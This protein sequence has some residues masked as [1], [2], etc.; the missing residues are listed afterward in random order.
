MAKNG[1]YDG[2]ADPVKSSYDKIIQE[3]PLMQDD[4]YVKID[5]K[6]ADVKE[7]KSSSNNIDKAS[8]YYSLDGNSWTKIGEDLGM[9]Y[10]L[11]LFTGYRSGIY[12][13]PTKNTGGYVDID[14]FDYQKTYDW[15][16]PV[17]VPPVEPDE[18][19]YYFHDTF[20]SDTKIEWEG[21]G[22]ASASVQ[23]KN[24][25]EGENAYYISDRAAAWHGATKKLNSGFKGGEEYSFSANFMYTEGNP[26]VD[27]RFTLQYTD[28]AGEVKYE[29]IDEQ[30]AVAGQYVQ[31]K[32]EHFAIPEGAKDMYLIVETA[33]DEEVSF[34]VDDIIGAVG[35]TVIEGAGIPEFIYYP[36]KGDITENEI[37]DIFDL[38]AM[39][40]GIISTFDKKSA[41][42]AADINDDGSVNAA[43]LLLLKKYIL[44]MIDSLTE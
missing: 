26:T 32:N 39:K 29:H 9:T 8:F 27:F 3:V 30:T 24:S 14:F 41:E 10:D 11:K 35:G 7:D 38:V 31:L 43:D 12:S 1:G 25:F 18:N 23:N 6:F 44:G 13:Y 4:V 2:S 33:E 19:G 5:F 22:G 34:Y 16:T 15:N 37:I 36:E 28:S 17:Y 42:Y 21:R 20:E 40:H